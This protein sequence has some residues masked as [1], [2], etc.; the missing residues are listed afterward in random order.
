M[1]IHSTT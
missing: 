1:L